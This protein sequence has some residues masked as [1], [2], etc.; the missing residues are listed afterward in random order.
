MKDP[1]FTQTNLNEIYKRM[2]ENYTS[3][4]KKQN[5]IKDLFKYD[6]III[7]DTYDKENSED[8]L[9]NILLLLKIIKKEKGL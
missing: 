4:K 2:L 3:K 7:D 6:G 1:Y 5:H 9:E 8:S